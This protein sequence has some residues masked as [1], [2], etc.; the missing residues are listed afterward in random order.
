MF[1]TKVPHILLK[2][3][4]VKGHY[5]ITQRDLRETYVGADGAGTKRMKDILNDADAAAGA[6]FLELL[7]PFTNTGIRSGCRRKTL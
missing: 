2:A 3:L 1:R 5:I 6:E 4:M 7:N